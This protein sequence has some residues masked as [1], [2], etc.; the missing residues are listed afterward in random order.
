[1]VISFK[2]VYVDAESKDDISLQSKGV[3]ACSVSVTQPLMLRTGL[4]VRLDISLPS[5][6]Q[7][8]EELRKLRFLGGIVF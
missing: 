6:G 5:F 4:Q 1:M 7:D 2:Y 8:G 3:C